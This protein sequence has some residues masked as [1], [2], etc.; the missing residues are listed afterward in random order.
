MIWSSA[1]RP[2]EVAMKL[3]HSPSS[4]FVRKVMVVA[5]ETGHTDRIEMGLV[6]ILIGR[7]HCLQSLHDAGCFVCINS[8]TRQPFD[9]G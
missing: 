3:R 7:Q 8:L 1:L 9:I 4:P 2:W 6:I 5:A